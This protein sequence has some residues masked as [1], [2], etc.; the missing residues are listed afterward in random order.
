MSMFEIKV[1]IP[2]GYFISYGELVINFDTGSSGCEIID[3]STP[4]KS[5]MTYKHK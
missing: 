2:C 1:C 4:R 3:W 5:V